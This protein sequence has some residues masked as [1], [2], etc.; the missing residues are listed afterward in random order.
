MKITIILLTLLIA[1]MQ[2]VRLDLI[3]NLVPSNMK[4]VQIQDGIDRV[5]KEK[6]LLGEELLRKEA[7]T[8][9]D[10][11]AKKEGFVKAKYLFQP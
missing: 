8:Y 9:I 11:K 10:E 5:K 1:F 6:M 2:L 4:Y 3:N 7:Y